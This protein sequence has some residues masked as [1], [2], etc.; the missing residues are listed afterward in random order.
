MICSK[1]NKNFCIIKLSSMAGAYVAMLGFRATQEMTRETLQ[2]YVT[3]L[4][5]LAYGV[6][7][8]RILWVYDILLRARESL[9][10]Y[11]ANNISSG[12]DASI[13]PNTGEEK[14]GGDAQPVASPT[15]APYSYPRDEASN[16]DLSADPYSQGGSDFQVSSES[17]FIYFSVQVLIVAAIYTF[18]WVFC[19]SRAVRLR[20]AYDHVLTLR[21]E[22]R[23]QERRELDA[24][25][26]SA[27][28]RSDDAVPST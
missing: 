10:E 8:M 21:Q 14:H 15:L 11:E 26:A 27:M 25:V 12:S 17:M 3:L 23:A 5:Y 2:K 6:A 16:D 13:D 28:A 7:V 22:R 19:V 18:A 1:Y 4:T 24:L 20:S 9:E